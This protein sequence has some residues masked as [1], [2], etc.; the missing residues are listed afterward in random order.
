MK[1]ELN[2]AKESMEPLQQSLREKEKDRD[3]FQ[4]NPRRGGNQKKGIKLFNI[5]RR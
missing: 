1:T 5:L 3:T 2:A 4:V